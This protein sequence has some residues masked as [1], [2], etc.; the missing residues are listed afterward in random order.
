[1]R[2]QSVHSGDESA[3][4]SYLE[5][6]PLVRQILFNHSNAQR[7][8][9]T[10]QYDYLNRLSSISSQPSA[11][12]SSAI[13]YS[14]AYNDANQRTRCRLGDGN[15]WMYSYDP[16]GQLKSGKKFWPDWT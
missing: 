14:Y 5:N 12:G 2:L 13:G 1:S 8:V 9:T 4:Y 3:I 15:L 6:S 11:I 10:K 7:M 16:L